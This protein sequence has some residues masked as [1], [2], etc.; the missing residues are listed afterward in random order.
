MADRAHELRL[1]RFGAR[2]AA[3]ERGRSEHE[4]RE[5]E[6]E[7]LHVRNARLICVSSSELGT[8]PSTRLT[9]RPRRSTKK[10]VGV[11]ET[12]YRVAIS[13]TSSISDRVGDTVLAGE[14]LRGAAAV[15]RVDPDDVAPLPAHRSRCALQPRHLLLARA[16]IRGPEVDDDRLAAERCERHRRPAAERATGETPAPARSCRAAPP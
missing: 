7:K 1:D 8:G 12:P 10:V 13:P 3:R 6:R 9:I 15:D 16:A 5:T 2:T 4:R 11:N 14:V